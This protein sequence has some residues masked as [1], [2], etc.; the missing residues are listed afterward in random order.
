MNLIYLMFCTMVL[1][2]GL[3]LAVTPWLMPQTECFSVTVPHGAR[4]E[5]PLHSFMRSYTLWMV[6]LTAL[7]TLAWPV[8]LTASPVDPTTRSGE[9]KLTLLLLVTTFAPL[10]AS[11]ALM[12]HFRSHV[13]AVKQ[14]CSWAPEHAAA[15]AFVGT[16]NFPKPLSLAWNLLYLPLM[17]GLA[18]FTLTRYDQFP[19][20]IPMNVDLAGNVT[21]TVPKTLQSVLFPTLLLGFMGAIFTLVH[22]GTIHSKKPIDPAA[23]ATSALAYAT[24]AHVQ[25]ILIVVGGLMISSVTASLILASSLGMVSMASAAVITTVITLA[26]VAMIT[27]VSLVMGQSGSRLFADT[28]SAGITRDDDDHWL[29]GTIYCNRNDPSIFVPKRFG[30]GWTSNIA[31]WETWALVA[32]IVVLTVLLLVLTGAPLS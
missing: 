31:R 29:L 19:S 21:S 15:A 18:Y 14:E 32:G 28:S 2:V 25:S 17:G 7:C 12:L 24:F 5:E 8:V 23:P 16:E 4:K 9:V 13:Q 22:W 11:F 27:I 20:Q 30:I 3:I 26:F 6:M 1:F 10:I